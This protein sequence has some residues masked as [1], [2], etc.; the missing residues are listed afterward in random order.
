MKI[1][2]IRKFGFKSM[3]WVFIQEVLQKHFLCI[4]LPIK[5]DDVIINFQY[6][7][8]SSLHT[9]WVL[10]AET[11]SMKND[12][13]ERENDI[14]ASAFS[15]LSPP[16]PPLTSFL[17]RMNRKEVI[18]SLF[19]FTHPSSHVQWHD[20]LCENIYSLKGIQL[21]H[22]H[23]LNF[24]TRKFK[25]RFFSFSLFFSIRSDDDWKMWAK[26]LSENSFKATFMI[27]KSTSRELFKILQCQAQFWGI[28]RLYVGRRR[29]LR[30]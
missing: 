23:G 28:S 1:E 6:Y 16:P 26:N 29:N 25:S 2:N 13:I 20:F 30:R 21:H 11:F 17:V 14:H 5:C 8:H 19:F 9:H 12:G 10:Q 7:P 24:L 3:K 4:S 18:F 27:A 15:F 22:F